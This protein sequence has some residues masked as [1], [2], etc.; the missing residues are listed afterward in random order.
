M[1]DTG[2]MQLNTQ[3]T[4]FVPSRMVAVASC[5]GLSFQQEKLEILLPLRANMSGAK[6]MQIL[7]ESQTVPVSQM[8]QQD[9]DPKRRANTA[10]EWL[11]N[12]EVCILE[13]LS[14]SPDVKLSMLLMLPQLLHAH[15]KTL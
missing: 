12:K 1:L 2:K 14:Q 11:E 8:S 15:T 9:N 4:S 6:F 5:A 3:A 10:Y 13:W 7:E